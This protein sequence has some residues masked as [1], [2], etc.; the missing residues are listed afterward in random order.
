MRNRICNI[1][2]K[3]NLFLGAVFSFFVFMM[4]L[5]ITHSALWGD[6]WIEY[7]YSQANIS[8]GDLYNKIISTFQPPLYNFVMHFWLKISK[9]VLWF[10][11]FNVL[12]GCISGIFLFLTITK[13]FNKRAAA[14]V[15]CVLAISY[16]WIYCIQECSEYALMV[17]CLFGALYFYVITLDNFQYWRMIL[18]I[19][20]A[21]LAMYSQYGA[22]FVAFP[23][24]F[25]FFT[26]NMLNR[27]VDKKRKIWIIF[28][29]IACLF[30]FAAPLYFCFLQKQMATNQIAGHAV[31][32][33]ADSLRDF[34]FILGSILGYLY[35]LYSGNTWKTLLDIFGF[36]LIVVSVWVM[37]TGKLD[38]IKRS[39]IIALWIG[40][41]AHYLL[42]QLHIYAM[43]HPDES[44][45]FLARYS[46]FYIPFLSVVLPIIFIEFYS[47]I[48]IGNIGKFYIFFSGV[49][50]A[51]CMS[52]S[53]FAICNNWRKAYDDEFA[54]VWMKFEGWKEKT[55]L[56]GMAPYGFNY[57]VTHS[58]GYEDGYLDNATTLV[59]NYNLPPRFWAWRTNWGGEGWQTTID[60]ATALGYTV[61]MFYDLGY[62][63]QLAYC[64]W[65][66][67]LD[68]SEEEKIVLRIIDAKCADDGLFHIQLG[69]RY[70]G[71]QTNKYEVNNCKISYQILDA[72][73][74]VIQ[75][76]NTGI[77][78]DHWTDSTVHEVIISPPQMEQTNYII[79]LGIVQD[80]SAWISDNGLKCP[81]III[82]DG[83]ILE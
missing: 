60:T 68:D 40:Y 54:S 2:K 7:D 46:Y 26:E 9:T 62:V 14:F 41:T 29:Y 20:C 83:Q 51:I 35:N 17:C 38:W 65:D 1:V 47:M 76:N 73:G 3:E 77:S 53:F 79:R 50:F 15:L 58:K 72:D 23:L 18:F 19:L 45:G 11:C 8:N 32:L 12:L 24:L 21:V 61:H 30:I 71:E 59:D 49:A 4:L 33:T 36:A 28:S 64:T 80:D 16:Q 81:F 5:Q 6:E 27:N 57:Y 67:G 42:V 44:A 10:R 69:I 75:G 74:K 78:I 63:G 55:Y 56:Y 82:R 13:L 70:P 22:I 37:A 48:R 66:K 34:P 25:L 39:L 52:I 43:V 31:S